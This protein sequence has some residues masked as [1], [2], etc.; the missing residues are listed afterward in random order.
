MPPIDERRRVRIG[1]ASGTTGPRRKCGRA[2]DP[3][4]GDPAVMDRTLA[5]VLL[6]LQR[7]GRLPVEAILVAL[8]AVVALL[9]VPDAPRSSLPGARHARPPPRP[10][11]AA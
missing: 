9:L 4:P 11:P 3:A 8:A 2:I 5:A 6:R 10:P 1:G 7:P